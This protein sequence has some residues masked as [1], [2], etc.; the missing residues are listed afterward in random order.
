[1]IFRLFSYV[2]IEDDAVRLGTITY[3]TSPCWPLLFVNF[4]YFPISLVNLSSYRMINFHNYCHVV[5]ED[6]VK[7]I[8]LIY[9]YTKSYMMMNCHYIYISHT[10]FPSFID[11]YIC[12]QCKI[13][14]KYQLV[15]STFHHLVL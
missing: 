8:L 6:V 3:L 14:D 9:S 12:Y 11:F 15:L 7:V 10:Q 2:V 1:V 13:F 4:N 5:R